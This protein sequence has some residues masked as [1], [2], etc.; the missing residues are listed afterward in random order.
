MYRCVKANDS[1]EVIAIGM[2]EDQG[3]VDYNGVGAWCEF[4]FE[5]IPEVPEAMLEEAS[6]TGKS[7]FKVSGNEIIVKESL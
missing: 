7:C 1:D 4:T 2:D 3:G 6:K 5:S